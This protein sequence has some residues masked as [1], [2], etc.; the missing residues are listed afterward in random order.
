MK[1]PRRS[2]APSAPAA[3]EASTSPALPPSAASPPPK[4]EPNL[5]D[6]VEVRV[7]SSSHG[8]V[9]DAIERVPADQVAEAQRL[10][11]ADP[12]PAA[13]TEAKRLVGLDRLNQGFNRGLELKL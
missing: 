8:H 10:G 9:V 1:S 5:S 13:V 6:M 12:D 7:I 11:W 2:P 3:A 4:S